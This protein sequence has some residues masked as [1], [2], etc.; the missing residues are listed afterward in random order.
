MSSLWILPCPFA[1]S[2]VTAL[3]SPALRVCTATSWRARTRTPVLGLAPKRL[4]R[5]G[6]LCC[7][8]HFVP[9]RLVCLGS[10]AGVTERTRMP[11]CACGRAERKYSGHDLCPTVFDRFGILWIP[12]F[13]LSLLHPPSAQ[14]NTT[15]R[16][17]LHLTS[18]SCVLSCPTLR[19]R[20]H[21]C[22]PHVAVMSC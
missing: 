5:C 12:K 10:G 19:Q 18:M 4:R 14:N 20:T 1:T 15:Q 11:P 3:A 9:C 16:T 13:G 17:H 6:W 8:G 21:T 7:T 22:W 2:L